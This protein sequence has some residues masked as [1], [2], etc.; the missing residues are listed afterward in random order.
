[1]QA[2]ETNRGKFLALIEQHQGILH[3]ICSLYTWRSED[4]QDLFQDML[5]QLWRSFPSFRGD[6][7]P[8]TWMYRVALNTALLQ[9]RTAQR[10]PDLTGGGDERIAA[11]SVAPQRPQ[12]A[13][14]L[15]RV[16]IRELPTL[17]R[18]LIL[19]YLE[20]RS[21]EEIAETTGLTRT[22]VSVRLVR[23]KGRLRRILEEKGL[24]KDALV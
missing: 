3:R 12:E 13:S 24:G 2:T 5:L 14:E 17:D 21:Y 15:L 1:M 19:L 23:L 10:R 18:A 9:Q 22:N 7:S 4:R 11:M 8:A 20:E 6:S 16:C